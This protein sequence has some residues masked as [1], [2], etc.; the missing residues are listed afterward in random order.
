MRF[1][2]YTVAFEIVVIHLVFGVSF[3][4]EADSKP[5]S[6]TDQYL[7]RALAAADGG[8]LGDANKEY[9]DLLSPDDLQALTLHE[10]NSVALAAKWE[11][12]CRTIPADWERL[13]RP[14]PVSSDELAQ[15]LGFVEGRTRVAIPEWW[16]ESVLELRAYDR[17]RF[18]VSCE[19]PPASRGPFDDRPLEASR[20]R[21]TDTYTIGPSIDDFEIKESHTVFKVHGR[22]L[23]LSNDLMFDFGSPKT[24]SVEATWIGE[25]S[26]ILGF[27]R[28]DGSAIQPRTVRYG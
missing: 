2:R 6:L 19:K 10:N 11:L 17:R 3:A 12:V 1:V 14:Q 27:C 21:P 24:L 13:K 7:S 20:F 22:E 5:A 26:C 9:M 8:D 25:E 4:Q 23:S 18:S 15:F 16:Q 28:H